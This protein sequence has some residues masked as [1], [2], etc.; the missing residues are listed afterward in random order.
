MKKK[1]KKKIFKSLA[2]IFLVFIALLLIL[3]MVF[4]DKIIGL[5]KDKAN[6]SL[7]ATLDFK[8]ADLNLWSSFPNA[9]VALDSV[10]LKNK[11]PFEGETLFSAKEVALKIPFFSIF[12]GTSEGIKINSFVVDGANVNIIIN[13][14]GKANYDITK[15]DVTATV[16]K[17]VEVET[18]EGETYKLGVDSYTITN[19]TIS[20]TDLASKMDLIMEEFNHSGKGTVSGDNTALETLTSALVSF[21]MDSVAYLNKN[22]VALDATL[23]LD[24]KNSKYS[25][26]DNKLTVNQLPLI[27]DGFVQ[28]NEENQEFDMSFKTP[29]SDFKHFL[30]LIPETYSKSIE[31]VKTTGNFD[32]NGK[33]A[34]IM[35]DNHIPKFDI[36]IASKNSSFKYPDLPKSLQNINLLVKIANETG[37]LKDTY[38]DINNMSFK[39]DENTFRASAKLLEVTE[40]MKVAA[41]LSGILNLGHLEQLYPA[42]GLKGLKG[43]LDVDA[44]TNFAMSAIENEQYENTNISGSFGLKDF[45]YVSDELSNPLQIAKAAVVF[46]PKKVSLNE[47]DAKI[48]KTDLSAT[49]TIDN[50]LGFVFKD[51]KMQ[52]KFNIVSD[53]FAVSDF[54]VEEESAAEGTS[55]DE[56]SKETTSSE[57]T[58]EEIKIPSFLDA[59]INV[60]ANTV[61]YDNLTLKNVSGG[62]VIKDE[63]ATLKNMKS[64]I[65]GGALGFNGE[66]STKNKVPTFLMNLD[67]SNFNI[68]ESFKSLELLKVLAPIANAIQGKLNSNIKLSGNLNDDFTPNMNS[69]SGDLLAELLS[70]KVSTEKAPLLSGLEQ[71][72]SFLDFKKLNLNDI[73]TILSFEDGKVNLKPMTFNYQD[74]A[75]DVSGAHNFDTSMNYKAVLNVPAK[76]L[77]D[78]AVK[79]ITQLGEDPNTIKI[80]VSALISGNFK[81]PKVKTDL[82]SAVTDLTKQLIAKK[83][84]K[85]LG[86]GVDKAT[87]LL[88][89]LLGGAKKEKDSTTTT[90]N[91]DDAVKKAA[92]NIL[93]GLFGNKKK[94]K[95]T[96]N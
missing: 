69:I 74:I 12:K 91:N 82:K 5:V 67:A 54:M 58:S 15:E 30:G 36:A 47:F 31:G 89:G 96:V 11:A 95:D 29:S 64:N 38:V 87:D 16:E 6:E 18:E 27:F 66:V 57:T 92:T 9:E 75:I 49:G 71:N 53:T 61:L 80:P 22:T 76:Y 41:S 60:K 3:P 62:L 51:D 40:N 81:S 28:V 90:T 73:K 2:I 17:P 78:E 4:E 83:K 23:D 43:L 46:N 32:I 44:K 63:K 1:Q 7:N 19:T 77:G 21:S 34:G 55:G 79:L 26:L 59:T 35:D 24:L 42:E 45:E 86:Q 20:Y 70:S 94:K 10:S 72:L 14:D 68:A 13:E 56:T 39:I 84:E 37:L 50:L 52:G 65:F 25:F 85:L 48:G 8:D 88:G 33:V 93:G